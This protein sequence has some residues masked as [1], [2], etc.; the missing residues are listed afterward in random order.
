MNKRATIASGIFLILLGIFFL[1]REVFPDLFGFFEWPFILIGLGLIFIIGAIVS[2]QS[3]LAIPGSIISGI[4]GI[5]YVQH[6][7]LGF[8]SWAYMWALIPAIVGIGIIISGLIDGH[9]RSALNPGLTLILIGLVMF[10]GFGGSF[11][12]DPEIVKY[13]PVL[14]IAIG[15]IKILSII[16][17][18]KN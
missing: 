14:L 6:T 17:R 5:L 10:F 7:S 13:W 1:T 8:A 9:L 12:L 2:G 15:A 18:K 4:G 16:F 11:G 3:G